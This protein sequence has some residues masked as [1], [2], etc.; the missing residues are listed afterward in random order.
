MPVV[1]SIVAFALTVLQVNPLASVH[2]ASPHDSGYDYGCSDAN[3]DDSSYKYIK[4]P[5]KVQ[6]DH[7]NAS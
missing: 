4:Q 3:I 7:T 1:T 5:G 6:S 2:A